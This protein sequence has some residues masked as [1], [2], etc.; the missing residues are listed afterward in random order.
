MIKNDLVLLPSKE[1][2]ITY[3]IES[4][5]LGTVPEEQATDLVLERVAFVEILKR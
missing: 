3:G 5:E 1:K 2:A 4:G